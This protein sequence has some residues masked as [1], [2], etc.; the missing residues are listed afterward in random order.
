MLLKTKRFNLRALWAWGAGVRGG[1]D[2]EGNEYLNH[3][4]SFICKLQWLYFICKILIGSFLY[5]LVDFS[6]LLAWILKKLFLLLLLFLFLFEGHSYFKVFFQIIWWFLCFVCSEFMLWFLIL[7]VFSSCS[8]ILQALSNRSFFP[9]SFVRVY[10]SLFLL[11][12]QICCC[13]PG[14]G[15]SSQNQALC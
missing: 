15:V 10:V 13:L 4:Q 2:N 7:L 1:A 6:L 14:F 3:I 9:F 12:R 11:V 8:I 5:L